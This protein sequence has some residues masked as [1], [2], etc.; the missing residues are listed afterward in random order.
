MAGLGFASIADGG[1]PMID[2]ILSIRSVFIIA[3]IVL[4]LTF[5]AA[6]IDKIADP[7]MFAKATANYKL[8]S[9]WPVLLVATF[10]P[11]VE[12][13]CGLLTLSGLYLRGS[14]LLL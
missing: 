1:I 14:S 5:V 3:R 6:S 12:L 4:G 7:A 10:L 2:R 9:G 11:W 13:L 8:I